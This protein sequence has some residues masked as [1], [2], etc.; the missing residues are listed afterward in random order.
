LQRKILGKLSVLLG[1][2][3]DQGGDISAEEIHQSFY[4]AAKEETEISV[5]EVFKAFYTVLID[6]EKGPRAG[7]FIKTIGVEFVQKRLTEAASFISPDET[8]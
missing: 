5:K 1:K 7:W 3:L 4:E 8:W 6:K 2:M